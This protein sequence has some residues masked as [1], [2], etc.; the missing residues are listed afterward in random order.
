MAIS[1][2]LNVS[3]IIEKCTFLPSINRPAII[4]WPINQETHSDKFVS[5]DECTFL[6]LKLV[7][8][9]YHPMIADP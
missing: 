3:I 6:G 1:L 9:V 8:S 2:F 4:I 7:P 5:I